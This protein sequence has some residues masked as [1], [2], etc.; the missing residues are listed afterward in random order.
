MK[1]VIETPT[2]TKQAS[3]IWGD[4]EKEDF[5]TWIATH[6]NEGDVIS[7]SNGARKVRWARQGGGK[8]GGGRVIY[9]YLDENDAL[10]LVAAYPKNRRE[11]MKGHEVRGL[12]Q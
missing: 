12:K 2:F 8:S 7:G 3:K 5:I 11:T 10:L 6:W 4:E 1:T 9:F